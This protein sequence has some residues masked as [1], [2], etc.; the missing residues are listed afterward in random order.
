MNEWTVFTFKLWFKVLGKLQIEKQARVLNWVT[1]DP[2]FDPANLG[3]GFK[4]W[5]GRGIT[6][7]CSLISVRFGLGKQDFHRYLQVR[8]YYNK[9]QG[10]EGM[11]L[12]LYIS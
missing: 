1:Y 11:Q 10:G 8:D 4:Q 7:F 5:V 12:D 9:N 3:G 2:E 6:S